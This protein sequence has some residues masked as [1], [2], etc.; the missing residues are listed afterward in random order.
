M[1]T[2]LNA[3]TK[4]GRK[5]P[6]YIR[7]ISN[8]SLEAIRS[9]TRVLSEYVMP[10]GLVWFALRA[11]YNKVKAT[12]EKVNYAEIKTYVPMHYAQ[13]VIAGNMKLIQQPP[14]PSLHL[15]QRR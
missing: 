10:E 15:I 1:S 12:L 2:L 11:I 5:S 4:R 14:I 6:P 9:Q 8:V 3:H 13:K 7:F